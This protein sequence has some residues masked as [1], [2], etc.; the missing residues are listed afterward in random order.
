MLWETSVDGALAGTAAPS[1]FLSV[2]A[3][4]PRESPANAAVF[5]NFRRARPVELGGG[6]VVFRLS[7]NGLSG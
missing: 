3:M 7:W 1:D 2:Q 6:A 5:K 4:V